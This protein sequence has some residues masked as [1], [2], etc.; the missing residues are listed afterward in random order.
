MQRSISFGIGGHGGHGGY[1]GGR[2]GG[3]GFGRHGRDMISLDWHNPIAR[4]MGY[5]ISTLV[6]I[7]FIAIIIMALVGGSRNDKNN[8]GQAS[9]RRFS[10]F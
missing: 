4:T 1:G 9:K 2:H 5:I 6:L 10:F 8:D 7:I 3:F